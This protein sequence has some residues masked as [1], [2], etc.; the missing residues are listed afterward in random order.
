MSWISPCAVGRPGPGK[1]EQKVGNRG[2]SERPTSRYLSVSLVFFYFIQSCLAHQATEKIT[3][4]LQAIVPCKREFEWSCSTKLL[5]FYRQTMPPREHLERKSKLGD[6]ELDSEIGAGSW[7]SEDCG[8]QPPY[9]SDPQSR[10]HIP[11][12]AGAWSCPTRVQIGWTDSR[13]RAQRERVRDKKTES[14]IARG[15]L[16]VEE[17]K[18]KIFAYQKANLNLAFISFGRSN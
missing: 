4:K 12:L 15:N 11:G 16:V 2:P 1:P 13:P 6:V 5:P 14:A 9:R 7:F 17:R 3:Q 8:E 18:K 10:L